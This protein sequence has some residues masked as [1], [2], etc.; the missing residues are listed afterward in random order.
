LSI[1]MY[2]TLTE[3]DQEYVMK[4]ITAFYA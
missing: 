1:P 2:P 4:T 3:E